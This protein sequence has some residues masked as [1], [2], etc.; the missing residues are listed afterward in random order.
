MGMTQPQVRGKLWL[1]HLSWLQRSDP[2]NP[3][4][5]YTSGEHSDASDHPNGPVADHRST[6][7]H[8]IPPWRLWAYQEEKHCTLQVDVKRRATQG[9]G[10]LAGQRA[11]I[12][13][14]L[15]ELH[16]RK[17]TL[18]AEQ[19]VPINLSSAR[20]QAGDVTIAINCEEGGSLPSP[21]PAKMWSRWPCSWTLCPHPPPMGWTRYIDN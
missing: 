8:R 18:K 6:V 9:W 21:G 13:A 20:T 7:E 2:D 4:H 14:Q 12:E 11:A 1:P 5:N 17:S 10:K 3:H 16:H 15:A 19:A